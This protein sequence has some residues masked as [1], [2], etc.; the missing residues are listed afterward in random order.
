[1]ETHH[2]SYRDSNGNQKTRTVTRRVNTHRASASFIFNQWTD[3]SAD[4]N[5]I[6]FIGNFHLTRLKFYKWFDFTP[7]SN[8]SY[9]A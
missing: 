4:P 2:E 6:T 9:L 3:L 5:S 8:H 7:C 1:M